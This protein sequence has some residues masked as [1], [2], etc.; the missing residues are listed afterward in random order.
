MVKVCGFEN[1]VKVLIGNMTNYSFSSEHIHVSPVNFDNVF[2]TP[3]LLTFQLILELNNNFLRYHG[4]SL[5]SV[6]FKKNFFFVLCELD[7]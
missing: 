3:K 4:N 7:I 6:V 1:D 5:K 2:R